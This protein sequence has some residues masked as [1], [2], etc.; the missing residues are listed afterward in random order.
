[1]L[2]T[3]NE[4]LRRL[5]R[6][7]GGAARTYASRPDLVTTGSGPTGQGM[8]AAGEVDSCSASAPASNDE[9][10]SSGPVADPRFFPVTLPMNT[11]TR[12]ETGPVTRAVT[13]AV[14]GRASCP[15]RFYDRFSRSHRLAGLPVA[16]P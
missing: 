3:S 12:I 16:A 10:G 6:H 11:P 9:G 5:Q 7:N 2:R 1:M 14:T 13:R 15:A 4:E 8:S